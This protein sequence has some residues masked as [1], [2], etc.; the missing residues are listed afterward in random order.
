M[1]IYDIIPPEMKKRTT[2]RGVAGR[3]TKNVKAKREDKILQI[4]TLLLV[5]G[6]VFNWAGFSGIVGTVA[7]MSDTE[8]SANNTFV[9]GA[10]DF[11]LDS[12]DDF[13]P[14]PLGVGES[15]T[16]EIDFLNN[17]NFPKYKVRTDNF[18]GDLCPWLTLEG[19]V[20]GQAS[21]SLP[22]ES[23]VSG[24][25]DF[26]GP[27]LWSFKLTL[28][29]N[30]PEVV[31]GKDCKFTFE[32]DGS[33][34][35]NDL[36]FGDGFNDTEEID[37][38]IASEKCEE[39]EIRS[40]GYWKNHPEIYAQYLPVTLGNYVVDSSTRAQAVFYEC[41]NSDMSDKL[42]CQLLA[43]K[44]NVAH[45]GV[46]EYFVESCGCDGGYC[47]GG[48][49]EDVN[50][51]IN[52]IIIEADNLL[53]T[54]PQ[55]PHDVMEKM[56]DLL[57]CLNNL[58]LV[59]ICGMGGEEPM[60]VINKVY[61]DVDAN[62]G[63]EPDNEFIELYNSSR[64]PIDISDWIIADSAAQDMLPADTIIPGHGYVLITG[65]SST[66]GFWNIPSDV[67]EIVLADGKIGDG[68]DDDGDRVILKTSEG[69]EVDAM[70][71][72]TDTYAFNPSCP[73]VDEG[74]MLG[75]Y[76][77][78]F[79]TDKASDWKDYGLPTV[80]V[81]YP[82]GGETW[83][84]GR[85][86]HL[87]WTATN[88]TG[89][90]SDILIDLYYSADSGAT[91]GKIVDSTENDG[92]YYWRVPLYIGHVG[93]GYYVPSPN[94]RIKAVAHNKNNFMVNDWDMSDTDFC[95]PIDYSLLT[96][97]E[98]DYLMSLENLNIENGGV[99]EEVGDSVESF[100]ENIF[101]TTEETIEET[102][103]VDV[104]TPEETPLPVEETVPVE[105]IQTEDTTETVVPDVNTP[106]TSQDVPNT[107]NSTDANS[108]DANA[109]IEQL[110]NEP[111]IVIEPIS[112]EP[113][114]TEFISNEP[115]SSEP[116]NNEPVS[117]EP[118]STEIINNEPI[119]SEPINSE[120]VSTEPAP[121]SNE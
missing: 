94:A 56:K 16:R 1:L 15:A 9:A 47:G 59:K 61:Y 52:E 80:H 99:V 69:V 5:V 107:D 22:L 33:Q 81:D 57:D 60:L 114:S 12:P 45:F 110:I 21:T 41:G 11:I 63:T 26:V 14:S 85:S 35:K 89:S 106:D 119:N 50:K 102:V 117:S 6:V 23:F 37:S 67:I 55:P 48:C 62:H 112:N 8:E 53:K 78:G 86:Y 71:Y 38:F 31:E 7:Y 18:T 97:E 90:N 10:L 95:P 34:I 46:G 100:V 19:S 2:T 70:S 74:D 109:I 116:I 88:P 75:R 58:E 3:A 92:D 20:D 13:T 44:F 66:F 96:P 54:C 79:D 101:G 40:Q 29:P 28:D 105:V 103:P 17:F 115:I 68:L 4:V 24:I 121:A 36:P 27:D 76:P 72:G 104:V 93:T 82:N 118:V 83:Y 84:V 65:N 87:K 39:Y 43:M 120:P 98:R 108:V 42:R 51:T 91:W 111:A 30:A 25:V 73:D 113:V 77:N 64:Q 32:F 49:F